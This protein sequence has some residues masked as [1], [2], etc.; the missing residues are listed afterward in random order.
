MIHKY[1]AAK[2]GES[3]ASHEIDERASMENEQVSTYAY[4]VEERAIRSVAPRES[5]AWNANTLAI[6]KGTRSLAISRSIA[7]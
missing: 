3:I 2:S 7:G 4:L 6:D 1:G 5:K